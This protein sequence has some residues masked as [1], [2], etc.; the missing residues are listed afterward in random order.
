MK[1]CIRDICVH[2]WSRLSAFEAILLILR[3]LDYSKGRL[4]E[5]LVLGVEAYLGEGAY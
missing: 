1:S 3:Q 5:I 2:F 4:F